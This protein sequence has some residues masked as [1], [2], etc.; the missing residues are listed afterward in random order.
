MQIKRA[1]RQLDQILRGETTRSLTMKSPSL[2][3]S[4][5]GLALVIAMLAVSYGFCM[6]TFSLARGL[7]QGG[8]VLSHGIWQ[9]IASMAKMPLLFLSTLVVTFPS[10]YV[11]SALV[12]CTLKV[13]EVLRLLISALAV[14]LA[15]LASL[16]PIVAFFSV[17]TPSYSFVLLLNVLCCAL[18]GG[19]GLAFLLQTLHRLSHSSVQTPVT[20]SF[21]SSRIENSQYGPQSPNFEAE[22]KQPIDAELQPGP[23]R[24]ESK[25]VLGA[26][27]KQVF[28]IWLFVFGMVGAQMGWV[29]RPFIG[30]PNMEFAWLRPRDS[31]F[32]EAVCLAFQGLFA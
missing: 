17:S 5:P 16:G 3:I 9:T 31:N 26:N 11:F 15:V 12:G 22:S 18:A 7:E 21:E 19:L 10:L 14:N 13:S 25:S 1:V 8:E 6:G 24:F 4:T 23:L 27:V 20:A 2:D 28:V 32:F 29:L 30:S